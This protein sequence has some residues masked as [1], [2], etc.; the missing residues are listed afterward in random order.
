MYSCRDLA[1]RVR[2]RETMLRR[3]T[4]DSC[5]SPGG[6]DIFQKLTLAVV[7]TLINGQ[8]SQPVCLKFLRAQDFRDAE[9]LHSSSPHDLA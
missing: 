9:A 6:V 7:T 3:S 2:N 8:Q 4:S 1:L 5:R